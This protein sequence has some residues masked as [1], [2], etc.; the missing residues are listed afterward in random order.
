MIT[1]RK[2]YVIVKYMATWCGPC[3]LLA[4]VM[5]ALSEEMK[6]APFIEI[7]VDQHGEA[8]AE[9]GIRGVPTV[10]IFKDG[11]EIGRFSGYSP[12]EELKKKLQA[13][14]T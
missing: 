10:L 4:P 8:A 3:K 6:P 13:C 5:E 9:M 2:G 7:D 11:I 12:K 14:M 1:N